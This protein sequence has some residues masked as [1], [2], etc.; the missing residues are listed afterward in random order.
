[1]KLSGERLESLYT[2]MVKIRRFDERTVDLFQQGLVKGTAHSYVRRAPTCART[3]TSSEPIAGTAT[4][5][6]RARAWT[7]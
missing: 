5:S 1:M 7:A 2:T 6:P 3:T 4:A